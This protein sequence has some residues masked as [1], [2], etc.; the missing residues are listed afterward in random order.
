MR[1]SSDLTLLLADPSNERLNAEYKAWLDLSEPQTRAK[2]ARHLAALCNF[3]GGYV[4]FGVDDKAKALLGAA[5]YDVRAAITQDAISGIV[6]RYLAPSFQ[7]EVRL[8][9]YQEVDYAIVIVPGHGSTPVIAIAGGPQID[10]RVVGI[11][12]GNIY[13][14]D[15]GP[16][17]SAITKSEQWTELFE[18][19]LSRRADVLASIMR[20]AINVSSSTSGEA[21]D[22][23]R[24]TC[25]ATSEDFRFQVDQDVGLTGTDAL[26]LRLGTGSHVTLGYAVLGNDG[27]PI[28]IDSPTS[29]NSRV[30]VALHRYADYGWTYFYQVRA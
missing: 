27:R 23:L 18:R 3:D 11:S 10:G 29:I 22:L 24:A 8:I 4:V 9:N 2:L 16:Q 19:C 30:N 26:A 15:T 21:E 17:S 12:Q 5:P 25:D 20:Q 13:Y 6:R 14:R 28:R 7:C 1:L